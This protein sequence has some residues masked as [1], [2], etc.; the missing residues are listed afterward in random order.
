MLSS[1]RTRLPAYTW[2]KPQLITPQ[3]QLQ[4]LMLST[5]PPFPGVRWPAGPAQPSSLQP[6]PSASGLCL[7]YPCLGSQREMWGLVIGFH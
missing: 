4:S 1:S 5:A 3:H 2:S 6:I 7:W